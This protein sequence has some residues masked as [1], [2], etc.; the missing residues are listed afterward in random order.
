MRME[1]YDLLIQLHECGTIRSTA[2]KILLSQPAITQR[3][4]YIEEELGGAI[5]VRTSKKLWITPFGELALDSAREI[6]QKEKEL[7]DKL[8]MAEGRVSG[9]L[10]IGA[11]SLYSQYFLPEILQSFTKM[12]PE[13]TIDLITGISSEVRSS[14]FDNHLS[15]VRG[16]PISGFDSIHLLNDPLYL[17]DLFPLPPVTE[18]PF[19]EFKTDSDF[20]RLLEEWRENQKELIYRP[21]MK[22]DHFETAKQMMKHGLG[23]TVLPGS[24]AHEEK[25]EYACLPLVNQEGNAVIRETWACVKPDV[26]SLPQVDAFL[27]H[28]KKRSG[29][30]EFSGKRADRNHS[31]ENP[32]PSSDL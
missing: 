25:E 11:S 12:Y 16:E 1:D 30:H 13:V 4:K 8:A 22:V 23:M 18:R 29:N 26:R 9:T 7:K 14:A 31:G 21:T 32:S 24:I 19:I 20:T 5:F 28:L 10:S 3:L 27:Q 2:K 6:L 17:F 15:I